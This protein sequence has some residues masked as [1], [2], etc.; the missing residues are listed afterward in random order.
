MQNGYLLPARRG[1]LAKLAE[2]LRGEEGLAH[3][4]PD[5]NPGPNPDPDPNP[6]PNPNPDL[7][8]DPDLTLP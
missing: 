5:P 3:P 8:P 1:G 7:N 4:N 2:R 6:S